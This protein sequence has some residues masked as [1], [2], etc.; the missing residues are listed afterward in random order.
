MLTIDLQEGFANDT[1]IIT[2]EGREILHQTDLTTDYSIGL[3]HSMQ[4]EVAE[5]QFQLD[6]S[7]PSR[8][9]SRTISLDIST[10]VYLG[11]SL[12]ESAIEYQAS[13]EPFIYF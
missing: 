3:A 12:S 5:G 2:V 10:P 11:L 9:L 13:D 8:Q 7:V 6:V 1:V 4:V